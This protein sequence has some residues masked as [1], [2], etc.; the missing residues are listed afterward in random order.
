MTRWMH[1]DF[2]QGIDLFV[3]IRRNRP[4]VLH[5]GEYRGLLIIVEDRYVVG[6]LSTDVGP[7]FC[8]IEGEV[9]RSGPRGQFRLIPEL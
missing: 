5:R 2:R 6:E 7:A 8:L 1:P 3:H 4:D 9:T